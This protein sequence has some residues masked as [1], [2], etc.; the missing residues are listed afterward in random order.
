MKHLT[1]IAL[2]CAALFTSFAASAD[3][4]VIELLPGGTTPGQIGG[5]DLT[6]FDEPAVP[7]DGCGYSGIGATST[8]SPLGGNVQFETASGDPLCM[9][10]QDPDWWQWDHGN[11][12]T[13]GVPWVELLMPS[14]TRAFTLFTGGNLWG[15]GWIEGINS[16]G[17]TTRTYFGGNTGIPFGP[18]ATPGFGVYTTG[19]CST[20]TR[21]VIEPFEWGT[22]NFASNQDGCTSVPEPA[23]IFL[24]GLGLLALA[25]A[26]RMQPVAQRV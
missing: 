14:G 10:V 17:N 15:R 25:I 13:T 1:R 4:I 21:I 11:V 16:N 22:G 9:T 12:F 6:P 23:P 7:A 3:E 2:L 8:P 24:L 20:I 18:G 19:S 5:F 26:R